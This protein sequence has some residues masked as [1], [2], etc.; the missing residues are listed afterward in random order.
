MP[1]FSTTFYFLAVRRLAGGGKEQRTLMRGF[2]LVIYVYYRSLC[3]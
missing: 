3:L 1:A 2:P